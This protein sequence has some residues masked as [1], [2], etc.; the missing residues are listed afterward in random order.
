MSAHHQ[1][2]EPVQCTSAQGGAVECRPVYSG[3]TSSPRTS[4]HHDRQKGQ[5][6][7]HPHSSLPAPEIR[8]GRLGPGAR[9][10]RPTG[11]AWA[12]TAIFHIGADAL[13]TNTWGQQG[14]WEGAKNSTAGTGE[15]FST[16][17]GSCYSS[18]TGPRGT[19]GLAP[20]HSLFSKAR[21]ENKRGG[22]G[23]FLH[24]VRSCTVVRSHG[25]SLSRELGLEIGRLG[26]PSHPHIPPVVPVW[27]PPL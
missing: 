19:H 26:S 2:R 25:N 6:C 21:A 14:P 4:R 9:L 22:L 11:P 12:P 18:C 3:P 20:K 13:L 5:L 10:P 17:S 1:A 7:N 15:A 8:P 27:P 16:S 23:A 24:H